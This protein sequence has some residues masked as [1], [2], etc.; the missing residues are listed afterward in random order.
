MI[1][2]SRF[3]IRWY[4]SFGKSEKG[5]YLMTRKLTEKVDTI[6]DG[7]FGEPLEYSENEAKLYKH[8]YEPLRSLV[9]QAYREGYAA[10]EREAD[11]PLELK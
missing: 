6:L 11:L 5:E 9:K 3:F 7:W 8:L 10:G 2:L 4:G 1:I